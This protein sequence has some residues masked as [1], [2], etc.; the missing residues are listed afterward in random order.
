[1]TDCTQVVKLV[2]KTNS[3]KSPKVNYLGEVGVEYLVNVARLAPKSRK[4]EGGQIMLGGN[5]NA[6]RPKSGQLHTFITASEC[7]GCGCHAVYKE[8]VRVTAEPG[9]Q[10]EGAL[11]AF[12]GSMLLLL[13]EDSICEECEAENQEQT[14][15]GIWPW[16][17]DEL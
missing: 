10:L 5:R 15:Q 14:G 2:S 16:E 1:M 8:T 3:T 9:P 6:V 4:G 11:E 17:A 7:E 12:R 13:Q